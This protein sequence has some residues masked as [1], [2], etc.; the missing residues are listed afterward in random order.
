VRGQSR[1]LVK[2]LEDRLNNPDSFVV[3]AAFKGMAEG[4]VNVVMDKVF[5]SFA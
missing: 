3:S 4:L 2:V 1:I 5:F